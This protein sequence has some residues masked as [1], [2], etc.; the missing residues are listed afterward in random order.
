MNKYETIILLKKELSNEQIKEIL[1]KVQNYITNNGNITKA[2]NL[3]LKKLA[4][5]IQKN[6]EAHYYLIKFESNPKTIYELE[7]IYRITDGIIK[8]IV[9]RLDD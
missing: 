5:E 1:N 7:R 6:K 9:I 2:E 8:F 4:Y 3:G